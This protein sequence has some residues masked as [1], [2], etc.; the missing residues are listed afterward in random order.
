MLSSIFSLYR[1][2]WQ[3]SRAADF[4]TPGWMYDPP[5]RLATFLARG[6]RIGLAI[7]AGFGIVLFVYLSLIGAVTQIVGA[8]EVPELGAILDLLLLVA[9]VGIAL[10]CYLLGL[11]VGALAYAIAFARWKARQDRR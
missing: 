3:L 7:A 2:L 4:P 6:A 5:P 1:R 10:I 9:S 11:L 8:N